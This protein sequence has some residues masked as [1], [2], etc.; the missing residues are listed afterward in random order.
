MKPG[1]APAAKKIVGGVKKVSFLPAKKERPFQF[2]EERSGDSSSSSDDDVLEEQV[3]N[4]S[5][6]ITTNVITVTTIECVSNWIF[7]VASNLIMPNI[8]CCV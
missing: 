1:K 2:K 7:L 6:L 8:K 5:L 4:F 3:Q